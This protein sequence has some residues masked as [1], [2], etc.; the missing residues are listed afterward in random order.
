MSTDQVTAGITEKRP[1]L[2]YAQKCFFFCQKCVFFQKHPKYAKRLTFIWE[3]G[4]FSL[5]NFFLS[6]LEHGVQPEVS[7]LGPKIRFLARKSVFCYRTPNFVKGPFVSI[8]ETVHFQSL[9]QFFDFLFLSY[10]RFRKRKRPTRQKVFPHPT[11]GAPSAS[12]SPGAL[13]AQALRARALRT[14]AG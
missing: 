4:I 2:W 12:N 7:F 11:V 13:S 14:R 5:H 1:F 8:G 6:W 3:K 9:D 10:G